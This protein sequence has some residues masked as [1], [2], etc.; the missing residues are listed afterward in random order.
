MGGGWSGDPAPD[1]GWGKVLVRQKKDTN[2]REDWLSHRPRY[3]AQSRWDRFPDRDISEMTCGICPDS[4]SEVLK[5]TIEGAGSSLRV[6][7]YEITSD[8]V[9]S[10]LIG[11]ADRGVDVKILLEGAPVGGI[12]SGEKRCVKR[13]LD[14]GIDVRFMISDMDHDIRDSYRFD[15]A[16]YIISDHDVALISSDNFKDSS[17]PPPGENVLSTTRGWAIS[18][19]SPDLNGDLSRVFDRDLA[20][21]DIMKA[22]EFID[23]EGLFYDDYIPTSDR[24]NTGPRFEELFVDRG[25][26][27]S[28]SVSP[29]N[30]GSPSNGL[31]DM[32]HGADDEILVELLDISTSWGLGHMPENGMPDRTDE[33]PLQDGWYLNPYVEALLRASERGVK[34]KILLDGTDFNGDGE[35]ENLQVADEITACAELMDLS[36]LFEVR[37]HPAVRFDLGREIGNIHNKGV[38]VDSEKVWISSF[39]W[40]PT[41]GLENREVGVSVTSPEAAGYYRSAFIHDWSGTLQDEIALMGKEVRSGRDEDGFFANVILHIQWKGCGVLGLYMASTKDIHNRSLNESG[42]FI[43]EGYEGTVALSSHDDMGEFVLIAFQDERSIYLQEIT[44]VPTDRSSG[45]WDHPWYVN[46]FTPILMLLSC[47]LILSAIR[48]AAAARFK[49]VRTNRLE[50]A[51]E[52]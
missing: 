21:P 11:A 13:L 51:I 40:G 9:V 45:G 1:L 2:T 4:G 34:V 30:I 3:P 29:D 22:S 14:A 19:R 17:F 18:M 26:T 43:E 47:A 39:N 50:G 33:L 44:V 42:T 10:S 31:L 8:W 36:G 20:G 27:G 49:E 28:L 25:G 38:I 12:S 23:L 46:P 24:E 15:H 41:S 6:N 16:K 35:P 32:I 7:V 52:E 48:S 37:V 5:R